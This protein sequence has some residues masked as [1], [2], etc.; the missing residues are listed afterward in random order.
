MKVFSIGLA[1]AL[2]VIAGCG[3]ALNQNSLPIGNALSMPSAVSVGRVQPDNNCAHGDAGTSSTG[4]FIRWKTCSGYVGHMTYG[5]GTTGGIKLD[6][7]PSTA[8]PGGIPVPP[9]ETPVLFVQQF[10][11]PTDPSPVT[12]TAPTV[13]PAAN[14]SRITGVPP[15][16]YQL[17][18][19]NGSVQIAGPFVLGSPV[20]GILRF[21]AA[22]YSPLPSLGTQGLGTTY[23]FELVTP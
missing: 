15:G 4:G 16:T 21:S 5:S 2:P 23:T 22:P 7:Q 19:Y 14:K 9:G 3:Q 13:P 12:F 17:Y 8:N 18:V 6:I 11:R 10:V 20:G 1:L